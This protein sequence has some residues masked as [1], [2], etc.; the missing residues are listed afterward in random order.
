M[1]HADVSLWSVPP[2]LWLIVRIVWLSC[3][4]R[5]GHLGAVPT[6]NGPP[7]DVFEQDFGW[8]RVAQ[9]AGWAVGHAVGA[10]AEDRA[11]VAGLHLRQLE[12]LS[13]LIDG[14]APRAVVGVQS[15]PL[16]VTLIV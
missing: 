6:T 8:C 16:A 9:K 13:E 7:F 12:N 2:A 14:C 11:E 4:G 5:A 10:G 1:S 3:F 15:A